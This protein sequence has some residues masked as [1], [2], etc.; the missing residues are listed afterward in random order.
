MNTGSVSSSRNPSWS[1]DE[2]VLALDL[3]RRFRETLPGKQSAEIAELPDFLTRMARSLGV[4]TA[5]TYRNPNG[6]YLNG[7][8]AA[9]FPLSGEDFRTII[10]LLGEEL[11]DLPGLAEAKITADKLAAMEER[12]L[13]AS[14]EV[15]ARV[16]RRIE[17]GPVGDLAKRATGYKCQLCQALS[18]DPVGFLK[19][20]GEP[21]VEAHHVMPV[22][23]GQVG[24]LAASNI[25]TLCAN[26]HRRMHYGEVEIE[27]GL[28]IFS[29]R[30]DG[31]SFD[32]PRLAIL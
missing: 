11:D 25:M 21:Y 9:S 3:Y 2:L 22:A 16:S 14:P 19:K 1:R 18:H 30:F 28:S 17:R 27:I 6:V 29:V 31:Y 15:K 12:Y 8:Q 13:L 4:T 5:A 20:S 24:S 26:H 32:I 10:A 23:R 7:F